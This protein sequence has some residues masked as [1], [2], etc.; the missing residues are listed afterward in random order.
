MTLLLSRLLCA[1]ALGTFWSVSA[2]SSGAMALA[3][4][5]IVEVVADLGNVAWIV[6]DGDLFADIGGQNRRDVAHEGELDP[7]PLTP[8]AQFR[9]NGST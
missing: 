7:V 6:A 4:V 5:A 8:T 1:R 9:G 2:A 3:K